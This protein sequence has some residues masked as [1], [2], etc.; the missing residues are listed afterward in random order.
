METNIT[1]IQGDVIDKNIPPTNL[2]QN[3]IVELLGKYKG[4]SQGIKITENIL[5]KH[6]MLIGGTGSGKTNLFYHFIAQIRNR[7]TSNDVMIVFD[8]KG[9]FFKKFYRQGDIVLSNSKKYNGYSTYWNIYKEIVV[10]GWENNDVFSNANEITHSFFKEAITNSSQPFFPSAARDLMTSLLIAH[11]RL[12]QDD[13][14]F[15]KRFFNN[16]ALRQYFDMLTPQKIKKLLSASVFSDLSST[17]SY[18]GDGSSEQ[19]LGVLAELQNVV[20]QI[21]FGA[22][23]EDGRFS[24]REFVRNKGT[25]VLFVEYDLSV[26]ETLTPIYRLLFDLALKEAMGRNKSEG[27]VYLMCDEFKLLPNLQHIEDGVNFGR[28]LGV[29]IIAG[30]QSIEQLYEIYGESKG[31]NIAAGFSSVYAFKANDSHTREYIT[32]L[33]GKNIVLEQYKTANNVLVEDKRNG[34]VVEDWDLNVLKIG[35]A[36]VGLPFEKPFKFNFDLF[37]G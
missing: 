12:G 2:P 3:S 15:K 9:D 13:L 23:A 19:A 7:M 26:G 16:K 4:R 33:Y 24:V 35:E 1:V 11:I 20:R 8:S 29:K 5:S 21:L 18:I 37:R 17:L 31:R 6:S 34:N 10:D 32:N 27:N 25:K 36:I 22:F 28:S 30:I 14:E